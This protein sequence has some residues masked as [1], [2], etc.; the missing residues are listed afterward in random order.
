M[1][2]FTFVA[3][4]IDGK[5][6]QFPTTFFFDCELMQP[7]GEVIVREYD[8]NECIV[9]MPV[10][11]VYYDGRLFGTKAYK[12]MNEFVRARQAICFGIKCRFLVNG[13]NMVI[14]GCEVLV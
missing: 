8:G 13:C 6:Q 2:K 3:D 4:T 10:F 9:A 5:I 11:S 1:A 7:Q 12:S 14:N